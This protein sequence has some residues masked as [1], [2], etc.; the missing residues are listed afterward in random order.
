[1]DNKFIFSPSVVFLPL[2]FVLSLW[3]VF[4]LDVTLHLNL[5]LFGVFPRTFIGLIGIVCSPFLHSNLEHLANNSIPLL[6]LLAALR[7]FYRKQAYLIVFFGILLSG[8]ITWLI[9]RQN[10][11][12]GASSL[13][14]VL[15]SFMFFKGIQSKYY[16]L[17]ALSFTIILL[18]GGMV[19]YIFPHPELAD[20]V[21]ISWEGHLAGFIT[22]LLFTKVFKTETYQKPYV[23]DWEQ[24]D[25]VPAPDDF[26]HS[27]DEKGNFIDPVFETVSDEDNAVLIGVSIV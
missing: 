7:F 11:H 15:V 8:F 6:L 20:T 12:I 1:M 16:R 17:V 23:Y 13:I 10:Y 22:G 19:W 5:T 24:P 27:F 21:S 4:W 25:F 9:G 3:I 18:Y 26:I 2:F 14:Y